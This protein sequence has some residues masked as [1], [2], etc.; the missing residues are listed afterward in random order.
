MLL[1]TSILTALFVLSSLPASASQPAAPP[2]ALVRPAATS[3]WTPN[4]K[5]PYSGLFRSSRPQSSLAPPPS[6]SGT[7]GKP[8]IKC[9]M[10]VIQADPSIDPRLAITPPSD[11]TRFTMRAIEPTICR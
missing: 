6:P 3:T 1:L 10:T 9:G 8:E 2:N 5:N 11:G 7:T 4:K